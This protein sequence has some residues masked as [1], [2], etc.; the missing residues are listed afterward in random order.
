MVDSKVARVAPFVGVVLI[1]TSPLHA[2]PCVNLEAA[3]QASYTPYIQ[4][5]VDDIK[6][7]DRSKGDAAFNASMTELS[8]TYTRGAT[9]G[10]AG[11]VRRL[12][13]IG[14]F[15]AMASNAEP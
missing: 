15:T 6:S 11:D 12:I 14:L 2:A 1:V 13:G 8:N 4:L 5:V 10:S 7:I 3:R 9:A